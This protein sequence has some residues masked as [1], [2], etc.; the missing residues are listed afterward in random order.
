MK[1]NGKCLCGAV[2]VEANVT[3]NEFGACHC[4]MCRKWSAGGPYLGVHCGADTKWSGE[5]NISVYDSSQWA[6]RGFCNNCGTNLFYRLKETKEYHMAIGLLDNG[7]SLKF[8]SQVFIDEKPE[9]YAFANETV[10]LTGQQIFEMY[11]PKD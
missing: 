2:A 7:E 11:A 5:E 9:N 8:T 4:T 10:N 3:K 1:S 6:E